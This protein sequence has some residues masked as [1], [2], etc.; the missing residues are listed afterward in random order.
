MIRKEN[1]KLQKLVV[2]LGSTA[3]GKTSWSLKLSKLFDIEILV[4]SAISALK[5]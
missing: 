4:D 1:Q 3:S 5:D 2:I